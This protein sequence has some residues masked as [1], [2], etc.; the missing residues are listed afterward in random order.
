[1]SE[2]FEDESLWRELYPGMFPEER[3]RM[4]E[5]EVAKIIHLAGMAQRPDLAV[6]DLCCGPGRHAVPLARRGL[7]VTAVDRT[8][9]LLDHARERARLAGLA[10]DFV[11]AD[12]RE[13]LRPAAFDLA[14]SLFTSFGYFAARDE[15]LRSE[16]H[17]SELQS[18]RHLVCRLL[19]EK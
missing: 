10:I 12:M 1:M 9:F 5:E 2:W 8:R 17:T 6:L 13:F 11:E 16:E 14:L 18:L 19:L 3:F 7:A 4:G 15:D